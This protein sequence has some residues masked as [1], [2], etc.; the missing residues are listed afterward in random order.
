MDGLSGPPTAPDLVRSAHVPHDR[1]NAMSAL[2]RALGPGPLD[3]VLLFVASTADFPSV[4]AEAA[5]VFAPARLV[6][7]TTAGEICDDGYTEGEIVAVGFPASNFRARTIVVEDMSAIDGQALVDRMIVLRHDLFRAEP[8]WDQEFN[9]LVVDGLS[10]KEDELTHRLAAG[11]GGVPLFGGSAG[12]GIEYQR[13]F[14]ADGG[15]VYRNAAVLTLIRTRCPVTV[16]RTDHLKPTP[17]RM[18]VTDAD[19]ARRIVREINAEPAAR[20][21]ARI[22]GKDPDQLTTFTFAAHPVV[23]R[24]GGQHHVRSIQRVTEDG[25]LVFFCAIDEGLVLTLAEPEDMVEHLSR[26]LGKLGA[27]ERP[28]II[29]A[30]DCILRRREAEEKQMIG[31]ISRTLAAN[32][33]VGFSTYGEQMG[34]LHVNQTLTGVAIYPPP[35]EPV[36]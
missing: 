20:E 23:V 32:R 18:V 22:L 16:F 30:C 14:V 25:E 34:A 19:P 31:A 9:F 13:T 35:A 26:E 27:L 11:L 21:Y 29:L 3:L 10:T 1:P 8:E 7:C 33:V 5:A 24:M 17:T 12:D 6:A 15:I 4:I 28:D 36:A 2:S